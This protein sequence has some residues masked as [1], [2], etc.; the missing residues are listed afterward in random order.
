[1]WNRQITAAVMGSDV[2]LQYWSC[3]VTLP[4]IW[5]VEIWSLK[6]CRS[7]L[8]TYDL[9]CFL[10]VKIWPGQTGWWAGQSCVEGEKLLALL[11]KMKC[12]WTILKNLLSITFLFFCVCLTVFGRSLPIPRWTCEVYQVDIL[13][14]HLACQV[15]C[16]GNQKVFTGCTTLVTKQ[17]STNTP[18]GPAGG[19]MPDQ[20]TWWNARN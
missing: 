13:T 2:K 11:A 9:L 1:M 12:S 20:Q 14:T 19:K 3:Q 18:S 5:I 10:L 8:R 4:G 17:S 6:S 16:Q 15:M 7:I